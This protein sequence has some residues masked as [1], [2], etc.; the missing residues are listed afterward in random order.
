MIRLSCWV[1]AKYGQVPPDMA[2]SRPISLRNDFPPDVEGAEADRLGFSSA[3][4]TL[5]MH[6]V[7][8]N[9]ASASREAG[10]ASVLAASLPALVHR[11]DEALDRRPGRTRAAGS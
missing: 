10:D 7:E 1:G 11:I 9:E 3:A 4:S 8:D 5:L 2:S 6:F